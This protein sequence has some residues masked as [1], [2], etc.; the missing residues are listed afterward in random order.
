MKPSRCRSSPRH[1]N[2]R[3]YSVSVDR[4][5]NL[6]WVS[7]QMADKIARFNPRRASGWS[8]LFR[9]PS[10]TPEGLRSIKNNPN[11]VW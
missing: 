4:K 6:I 11:R 8:S 9:I 2:A 3:T 7:E 10:P 5:N 1:G